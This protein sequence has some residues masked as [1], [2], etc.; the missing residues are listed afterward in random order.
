MRLVL[1]ADTTYRA[2]Q[3]ATGG[4]RL[5]FAD[6]HPNIRWSDRVLSITE[7]IGHH[8]IA[9]SG[10][11]LLLM[12][13]IF[14]PKPAPRS[15]PAN[16]HSWHIRLPSR[17]DRRS[18]HRQHRRPLAVIAHNALLCAPRRHKACPV[19]CALR[20]GGPQRD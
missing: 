7:M 10:R 4:A 2:R 19:T 13:S 14:A 8:T 9:A 1:E 15:T 20:V 11:G 12:P 18:T 3:L 17:P 16:H 5:L 6:M